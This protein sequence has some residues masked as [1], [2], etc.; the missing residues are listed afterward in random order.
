MGFSMHEELGKTIV[1]VKVPVCVNL[2]LLEEDAKRMTQDELCGLVD[3][4]IDQY[5][6]ENNIMESR[7]SPRG[8]KQAVTVRYEITRHWDD[9]PVDEMELMSVDVGLFEKTGLD[10][11]EF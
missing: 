3:G 10:D 11:D 8:W 1:Q 4:V 9:L 5:N 2:Q 6:R 7:I